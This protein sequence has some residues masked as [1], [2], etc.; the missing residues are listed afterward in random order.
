MQ[1]GGLLCNYFLW[2]WRSLWI[3]IPYCWMFLIPKCGSECICW[4]RDAGDIGRKK[5]FAVGVWLWQPVLDPQIF[6]VPSCG[7]SIAA[8]RWV[9]WFCPRWACEMCLAAYES[10]SQ[11]RSCRC[12]QFLAWSLS[13]LWNGEGQLCFSVRQKWRVVGDPGAGRHSPCFVLC[14]FWGGILVWGCCFGSSSIFTACG[15]F[16]RLVALGA[17][18]M[19]YFHGILLIYRLRV[20]R[21]HRWEKTSEIGSE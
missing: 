11:Q 3:A 21:G 12:E 17:E 14:S 4:L 1:A 20:R 18:R 5:W 6:P 19:F 2:H 13:C 16:V 8:M 7:A 10:S 15:R 9:K